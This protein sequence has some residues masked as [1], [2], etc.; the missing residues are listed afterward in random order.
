MGIKAVLFDLDG[1]LLPMNQ[2]LFTKDYFSR[3]AKK[4]APL[5]YE[6]EALI[7]SIWAGIKAMVTNDGSVTNEVAFWRIFTEIWGEK[8]KADKTVFDEFYLNDF[9][10]IKASC[11][12][13]SEA[14]EIVKS[15]K[16]KGIRTVLATNPIFPA[17]ATE[18]RMAWAGLNPTDFEL[19]TTYENIGL[20][21]PNPAYY[22]E[23]LGRLGLEAQ[24]CL[25][26]GNDVTEDMVAEK[27][28]MKVFLLKDCII[29]KE[30]KD[31]S[32]YLQGGFKEQ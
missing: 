14:A 28:G 21:K 3:L 5:G 22:Q 16:L 6:T 8:A 31:I 2:E 13:S 30:N 18:W 27:L 11:G 12:F 29:N 25:M 26:V 15:L 4:L 24:D 17:V 1:T 23:I 19:Y 20:C 32:A 10:E 9:N 7:K